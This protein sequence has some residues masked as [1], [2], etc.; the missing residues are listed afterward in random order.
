MEYPGRLVDAGDARLHVRVYP[1][2]PRPLGGPTVVLEGGF[3][4]FSAWWGWI[5]PH[6]ARAATVVAYDR[7]GLG[8][9]EP[10]PGPCDAEGTAGAT[11]DTLVMARPYAERAAEAIAAFLRQV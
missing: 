2:P 7:A 11:H 6:L 8:W 1:G 9:S 4:A 10:A 3:G 5:A